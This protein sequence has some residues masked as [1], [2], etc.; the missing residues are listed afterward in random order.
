[1][2]KSSYLLNLL[3]VTSFLGPA[4]LLLTGRL[5]KS[6]LIAISMTGVALLTFVA[7]IILM[8]K[9]K[10]ETSFLAPVSPFKDVAAREL[11]K[12]ELGGIWISQWT[13][14]GDW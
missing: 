4:A 3:I 6:N 13:Y 7:S 14:M 1:M 5:E 10:N 2:K 8:K 9:I 11:S 12:L